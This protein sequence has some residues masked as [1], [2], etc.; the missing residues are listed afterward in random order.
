MSSYTEESHNY[1]KHICP[2][3]L[4]YS[5]RNNACTGAHSDNSANNQ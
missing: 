1:T 5:N 4:K 2:D 3:I